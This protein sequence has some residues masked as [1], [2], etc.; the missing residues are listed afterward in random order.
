M[1][2][3]SFYSNGQDQDAHASAAAVDP[4]QRMGRMVTMAGAALSLALVVGMGVWAYQLMM[5]DVSGVPVVRALEGPMRVQPEDPGGSQAPHQGLAVNRIA[6]GEEAGPVPDRLVLAPP[7]VDLE[8]VA[9]SSASVPQAE[10]LSEAI[11]PVA[12]V[13]PDAANAETQALIE[14]LV[15]EGESLGE[16]GAAPAVLDAGDEIAP[17]LAV[18]PASVPGLARSLRPASRPATFQ[19]L[20]RPAVATDVAAVVERD[21]ASL[22]AGTR[23]VQLGAFD[24]PEIAR[25]EWDRLAGRFPD[26]LAG[27]ERIVQEASSGG[28]SFYR[29]RTVG[30]DDLAEARRFCA[31]LVADGAACIPVTIR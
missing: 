16:T 31:A 3:T 30:F 2:E 20:A 12:P 25:A 9:F 24:S 15:A 27:R 21:A 28:A 1:A 7:P 26:F 4:A 5:R 13:T 17:T 23:L 19:A 6:E 8:E 14:R 10:V 18:L 11:A 22:A 29:L